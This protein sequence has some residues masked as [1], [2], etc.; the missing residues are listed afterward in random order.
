ME[1]NCSNCNFLCYW[2]SGEPF[3]E[4]DY[5]YICFKTNY[6]MREEVEENDEQD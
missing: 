5:E 4:K 3:C 6:I 1:K 2:N